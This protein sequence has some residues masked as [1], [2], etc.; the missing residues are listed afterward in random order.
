MLSHFIDID[1]ELFRVF[2]SQLLVPNL[3]QI[4]HDTDLGLISDMLLLESKGT[5][6]SFVR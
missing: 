2:N 6:K 4:K 5:V 1:Q 3:D